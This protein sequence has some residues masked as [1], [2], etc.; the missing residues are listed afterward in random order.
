MWIASWYIGTLC[1][2]E[3]KTVVSDV[4]FCR[5]NITIITHILINDSLDFLVLIVVD[6]VRPKLYRKL[7]ISLLRPNVEMGT[8]AHQIGMVNANVLG[9]LEEL[10]EDINAALPRALSNKKYLYVSKRLQLIEPW[11]EAHTVVKST[12]SNVV[13]VKAL[14]GAGNHTTI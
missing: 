4:V 1:G 7:Q 5:S 11:R 8:I 6:D 9:T 2:E 3:E 13:R 12:F 14:Y 10:R